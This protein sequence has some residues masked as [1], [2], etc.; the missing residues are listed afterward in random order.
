[1]REEDLDSNCHQDW[2]SDNKVP[3]LVE[4]IEG[5]NNEVCGKLLLSVMR[6]RSKTV[7]SKSH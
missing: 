3:S 2:G 7:K 6:V 4:F 1:M 5:T